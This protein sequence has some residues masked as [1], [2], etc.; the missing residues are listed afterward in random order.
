MKWR[1]SGRFHLPAVAACAAALVLAA[2]VGTAQA[3]RTFARPGDGGG[4]GAEQRVIARPPADLPLD[5]WA[6]PLLERLSARRVVDLDLST[7]PL[8][9]AA[10]ARAVAEAVELVESG[11]VA[12]SLRE[13]WM[14]SRLA[15]EFLRGQV[16]SPMLHTQSGDA[17]IGLG[18]TAFTQLRYGEA[19]VD[20][21]LWP[22]TTPGGITPSRD[23][24]IEAEPDSELDAASDVSY[25]LWGGPSGELGFYTDARVLLGGQEGAR[26]VQLSSRVR[27]WRGVSA[28]TDRAYFKFERPS[29]EVV[30]GRRGTAWGRS[31]WG[32][33]MLSGNAPTLD[34]LAARFHVG[35][36]SFE[37]LH[38]YLEYETTGTETDLSE[39]DGLFLAGHRGVLGG[40][41]GSIGL[42]EVVVYSATQPDPVY[43]NPLAPY[44]LLQHNERSNDNVLWLM[45]FTCRALPGLD[46]YGEFLVDDLQYERTTDNPDKYGATVG[47]V[48]CAAAGDVDF[49]LTAEY[50]NVRKWTYTHIRNE[51]RFAHD[52]MPLGFDLGPDA[53]RLRVEL[54]AHPA[55]KWSLGLSYARS[56]KGAGNLVDAFEEGE[57]HEPEFPSGVVETTDRVSAE[58][59]YQSLE[60]LSAGLGVAFSTVRNADRVV[61]ADDDDWEFW[62]GVRF[63]I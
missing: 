33:L 56:R 24:G 11:G 55:M 20:V 32:R 54:V 8:S 1:R 52:G 34:Q 4:A 50:T 60:R 3:A 39:D 21:P 13:A 17:S 57:N 14:L 28:T 12:M 6:Q 63:R 27:T 41:W 2:S 48:W 36:V 29:Y 62:A 58:L 38:A 5:H 18:L 37:A 42:A 7:L 26:Q 40:D 59:G 47:G 23:V 53:D 9:R 51:H 44:Y 10:V 16:D 43:L 25:E 19:V 31:R 45:D 49:E 46:L 61:G 22:G 15:A 35:P 30:L